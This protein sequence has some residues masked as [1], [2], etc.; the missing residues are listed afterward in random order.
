MRKPK[1]PL[2]PNAS[3][4]GVRRVTGWPLIIALA[5]LVLFGLAIGLIASHRAAQATQV[6]PP[7]LLLGDTESMA[8]QI[9]GNHQAGLITP[10]VPVAAIPIANVPVDPDAPP[11]PPA[12]APTDPRMSQLIQAKQQ[13]FVAAVSAKT[14]VALPTQPSSANPAVATAANATPADKWLLPNS[15]EAPQTPYELRTGG[16][17]PGLMISG[18]NSELPGQIMGQVSQDVYDTATGKY[19]LIPQGTRVIGQYANHIVYGQSAVLIAW[20]RLIFPDGRALDIETMPGADS[21]G[22]AG[23]RDQVDNHYAKIFGSA[24]LM[25]LISAG[26]AYGQDVTQGQGG[27]FAPPTVSGELSQA[28][29]QQL[30]QT[31]TQLITKNLNVAPTLNIR[32]GYRFN[33]MV[34]KDLVFSKPYQP[35]QGS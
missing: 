13:A 15:L 6:R 34:T 14:S 29:G 17:I 22:Y 21:A 8:R 25:S 1:D 24:L 23:F 3:P 35:F 20:Q 31:T 7:K 4:N 27:P 18:I 32:P 12:A 26:V 28:L 10:T 33:I 11:V 19:L 16:I 30:G 9:I 5:I 2:A